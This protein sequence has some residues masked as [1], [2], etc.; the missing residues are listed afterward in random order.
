MNLCQ[1]CVRGLYNSRRKFN[2][3]DLS[4]HHIISLVTDF[5]RRL[6][7]SNLITLCRYHHELAERG[8]IPARELLDIA[9]EQENGAEI[10]II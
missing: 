3:R 5:D 1:V 8:R 9:A 7:N 4:V 6:D 2:S 10:N